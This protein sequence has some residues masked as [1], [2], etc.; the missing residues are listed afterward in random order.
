MLIKFRKDNET[1]EYSSE[2]IPRVGDYV[3][4]DSFIKG[5]VG[6]VV[7]N[8]GARGFVLSPPYVDVVLS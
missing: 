7:W 3:V 5:I 1:I 8:F 6:R 2:T 4:L